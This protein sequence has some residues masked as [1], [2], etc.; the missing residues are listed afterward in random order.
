MENGDVIVRAILGMPDGREV[1]TEQKLAKKEQCEGLGRAMAEAM[2]ARGAK[3]LLARADKA[4][5]LQ[6]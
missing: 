2:I 1:L 5:Q 3:E 6:P 4:A